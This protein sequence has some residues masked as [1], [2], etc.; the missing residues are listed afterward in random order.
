MA[1]FNSNYVGSGRRF[2]RI[3]LL[4]LGLTAIM[5][6]A[7]SAYTDTF[8]S[9]P[10][11]GVTGSF[12][13]GTSSTGLSY[14]ADCNQL[15]AWEGTGMIDC[16]SLYWEDDA[17]GATIR[18]Y[19]PEPFT[20]NVSSGSNGTRSPSGGSKLVTKVTISSSDM[21]SLMDDVSVELDIPGAGLYGS[22][23]LIENGDSSPSLTDDTGFGTSP[24]GTP[25]TKTFTI[26]SI[27]DAS[28][29]LTGSPYVTV[30]GSADFTISVQP[31][32]DPIASGGS[33]T[34]TVQCNPTGAGSRTATVT[35]N[36]N[37][38]ASPYTFTVECTGESDTI[39]P[40][41]T[42][43]QAGGQADPTNGSPI[44]FTVVFNES[45]TGFA[46]GDVT[47]GGTAGA[48]T[49]T[50]TGSGTTYNV[51]VSG[52][53]GD[54]TVIASIAAG[55]AEDGFSNTSNASTSTDNTVTYDTTDPTDPTP[56]SSSHTVSVWDNDSTVD[57]QIS[58]ANDAGSGVDG[59]E[60]EWNQS[61]SWTPTET[62]E[63]EES[64]TGATFTATSDGDWYF[65]IATV[66]NAGNWT[67]TQHLGP[68]QIDTTD[69]TVPTGLSPANGAYT[70]DTSPILSW[71][72]STD[73]G[74]SGMRTTSA[75]RIVV[76]GPVNRDTY[77]SDTDY[78]PTLAEGTFIWKIYAR[79][80]AGNSS[81]YSSDTT[82][83]IDATPPTDPT[84]SSSSH[85]VSVWD[86]DDSVDIG[87]SGASDAI[88]G[89]DGSEVEWDMNASWT[90]T[91]TKE[92]EETWAGATYT[93]ATDGDW[94]FHIATVDN[95][96]NWT[97]TE[98][99]GPF[100]IDTEVPLN[101]AVTSTHTAGVWSN[102]DYLGM[103]DIET[104][105]DT[106]SSVDGYEYEFSISPT[107]TPTGVKDAEENVSDIY[108]TV[109]DG[110]WYFH[111]ATVDNAG[112]WADHD[113]YGPFRIDTVVPTNPL[114]TSSTH[115]ID[116]WSAF[117]HLYIDDFDTAWDA[118]SGISELYF[119]WVSE[120][121]GV[122]HVEDS[123]SPD[124]R[125]I[126]VLSPDGIWYIDC[127][128]TDGAGNSSTPLHFGPFKIDTT[129]PA[130]SG[131]LAEQVVMVDH[132]ANSAVVTWMEP[133]AVDDGCGLATL[134]ATHSPGDRFPVGTTTV[135]Y[136]ATDLLGNVSTALFDV[137]VAEEELS[138]AVTPAGDA[139]AFL[140]R[141]LDLGEGEEPPMIG[142]RPLTA[143]YELGELVSG[144][145]NVCD[146]GGR[147]V[148]GSFVHVYVYSVD[149]VV[150]PEELALVA[151]WTVHYDVDTRC[152]T[153]SWDT[154]DVEPG[155]YDIRLF[156][157]DGSSHT[158]RIQLVEPSV[159]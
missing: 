47:L 37:S 72:A 153:F 100:R 101:P 39:K 15:F 93:A 158:C 32:T 2:C 60:V 43:N 21:W 140:N 74:G 29:D 56:S 86:A 88:S 30:S 155:Y 138:L 147:T 57:I 23:N 84:P 96:G 98:H 5:V 89:V 118:L 132:G 125:T 61:A 68:F 109:S 42:I 63:Q 17:G 148:R 94:Y 34:F 11:I 3:V 24:V 127:E 130:I 99:L 78:N 16:N 134:L 59:F 92:H 105:S 80:N 156:F 157:A 25:V 12:T 77:V 146:L 107:W 115:T 73:T 13:T 31:T 54:G 143:I 69:P 97:S 126:G 45:V 114:L 119:W 124:T 141:C 149:V 10:F 46:T 50:V 133:T 152:Y 76:T 26:Q 128:T 122:V 9:E 110:D 95:A 52:M 51:A 18:G 64:W 7:A 112:N 1:G 103:N 85:T 14:D 4:A 75:Y 65:H 49:G 82:L 36:N 55:V 131:M 71:T 58:G 116:V 145:C 104:S 129:G 159:E 111:I 40:D 136:T 83:I 41:V 87:I 70:T 33:D 8:S 135:T 154:A 106:L 44:N 121:G 144:A 90:P 91:Q 66:D 35:I 67:S 137:I 108:R 120:G 48:T 27:G 113:T 123:L 20:I 28:L 139:G 6:L 62:K 142:E 150:R 19:G 117:N 79:D 151:H 38:E 53:T 102:D 81:S 22:G